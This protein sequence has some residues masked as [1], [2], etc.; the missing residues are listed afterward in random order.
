MEMTKSN[1]DLVD[2]KK[3]SKLDQLRKKYT[4]SK[5][6]NLMFLLDTSTSM[7][8]EKLQCAKEALNLHR[9]PTD[10]LIVFGEKTMYITPT[11]LESV[12]PWGMTSMLPALEEAIKYKPYRIILISDGYPNLGGGIPEVL[13]FVGEL[14]GVRIDTI[15]IG[16]DC[17]KAFMESVS[18]ITGGTNF[19]IDEPHELSGKVQMLVAPNVML[20][21]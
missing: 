12:Q 11:K 14:V 7:V 8:G 9:K 16:T 19:H 17:D 10:G 20:Q 5:T 6:H 4:K 13:E 2:N 21:E 1:L 18:E 3:E 15:G